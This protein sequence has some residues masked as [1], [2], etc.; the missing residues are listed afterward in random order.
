MSGCPLL[1]ESTSNPQTADRMECGVPIIIWNKPIILS[2]SITCVVQHHQPGL[3]IVSGR[4]LKNTESS[5][6][7]INVVHTS[8][9]QKKKMAVSYTH[10]TLP[11]KA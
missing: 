8:I 10:L 4:V 6:G 11:T 3:S 2:A 9:V 5:D 1:V 7:L